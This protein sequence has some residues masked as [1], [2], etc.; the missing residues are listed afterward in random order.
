MPAYQ[1]PSLSTA[2]FKCESISV[3]TPIHFAESG[4]LASMQPRLCHSAVRHVH[5][6]DVGAMMPI[7]MNVTM[8]PMILTIGLQ[9]SL[10]SNVL[11]LTLTV[12]NGWVL[13]KCSCLVLV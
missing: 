3:P 11:A 12:I 10:Y 5:I 1:T 2:D 8:N 4:L 9:T 13:L 7:V 6:A